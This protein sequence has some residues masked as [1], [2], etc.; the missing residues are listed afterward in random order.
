MNAAFLLMSSLVA[1]ADT[2][3]AA[4][5][6]APAAPL[7]SAPVLGCGGCGSGSCA[8]GICG[9]AG[10]P[11]PYGKP[12]L[13]TRLK[14]KFS[15]KCDECLPSKPVSVGFTTAACD[16]CHDSKPGLFGRLK[17]KFAGKHHNDG[18]CDTLCGGGIG[19]ACCGSSPLLGGC[20]LPPVPGAPVP[21]APAAP[22][23]Q[24]PIPGKEGAAPAKNPASIGL[25]GSPLASGGRF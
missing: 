6:P 18:A 20:A 17:A 4:A 19:S 24:M 3:P 1:G 8:T 5:A 14:N 2:P 9:G 10:D 22:P 21:A 23:A 11:C 7:V 16:P 12:G 13:F 25:P 15:G